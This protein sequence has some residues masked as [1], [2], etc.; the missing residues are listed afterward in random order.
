MSLI[1]ETVTA[2]NMRD[3]R[4]LRD[5]SVADM[6]ELRL[7]GVADIDVAGALQGR[8]R[9]VVLTCR[10]SS[11]GGRFDG[12][13]DDRLRILADAI[14]GR[15]EFVDVEWRANRGALPAGDATRLVVSHHDFSG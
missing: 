8:T 10:A 3:L 13:E 5:A 1:C 2:D 12:A 4:R 6:V 14:R 11:E 9:P 15:A 7:D